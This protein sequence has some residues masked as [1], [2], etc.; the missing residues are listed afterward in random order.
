MRLTLEIVNANKHSY[1]VITVRKL[2]CVVFWENDLKTLYIYNAIVVG[3]RDKQDSRKKVKLKQDYSIQ[4]KTKLESDK[5][6]DFK[7]FNKNSTFKNEIVPWKAVWGEKTDVLNNSNEFRAA[8]IDVF[9]KEYTEDVIVSSNYLLVQDIS[10]AT[11]APTIAKI[12]DARDISKN[13]SSLE[14][15]VQPEDNNLLD[16]IEL[17]NFSVVEVKA[18]EKFDKLEFAI[19]FDDFS[20]LEC[21]DNSIY[22]IMPYSYTAKNM[23][24]EISKDDNAKESFKDN[25]FQSL[26][27]NSAKYIKEW[28]EKGIEER[29]YYRPE[30]GKFK[31]VK[32]EDK[33]KDLKFHFGIQNEIH[34]IVNNVLFAFLLSMFF[35]YG[36]DATRLST[37]KEAFPIN[38]I[39][40]P[41]IHFIAIFITLSL[42]LFY[43]VSLG[44]IKENPYARLTRLGGLVFSLLWFII[45]YFIFPISSKHIFLLFEAFNVI[46]VLNA[47]ALF[48]N[49]VASI[50]LYKIHKEQMNT[51]F[52]TSIK[53][54]LSK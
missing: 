7:H 52:F 35:A 27:T 49:L 36:L 22:F 13:D 1:P 17:I 47:L 39:I 12:I 33:V 29:H 37:I 51:S 9:Q 11:Q 46:Y 32:L 30:D 43:K 4:I 44:A 16:S 41:E 26:E 20:C 38:T 21:L 15:R 19:A 54:I 2:Y 45:V 28:I 14:Y 24:A 25:P 34:P 53:R 42:T 40:L 3:A 48:F 5:K 50:L 31:L 6:Y 10:D 18:K 8:Y 23:Y